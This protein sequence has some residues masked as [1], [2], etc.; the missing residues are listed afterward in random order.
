MVAARL[1]L[2][3]SP[4]NIGEHGW[5]A[6]DAWRW[7]LAVFYKERNI[8]VE[9]VRVGVGANGAPGDGVAVISVIHQPQNFTQAFD[10]IA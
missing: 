5:Q 10:G 9:N 3:S 4:G 6:R 7:G 8:N 2:V 1:C